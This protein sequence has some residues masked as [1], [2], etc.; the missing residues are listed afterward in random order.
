MLVTSKAPRSVELSS[1]TFHTAETVERLRP[2]RRRSLD[3]QTQLHVEQMPTKFVRSRLQIV[4]TLMQS[5]GRGF[6]V[7]MRWLECRSCSQTEKPREPP[8]PWPCCGSREIP[9]EPMM[10]LKELSFQQE[11]RIGG[12]MQSMPRRR[13][14]RDLYPALNPLFRKDRPE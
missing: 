9:G 7:R 1:P 12:S 5:A 10:P 2:E 4:L 6:E 3:D 13:T 8:S 11:H 14:N